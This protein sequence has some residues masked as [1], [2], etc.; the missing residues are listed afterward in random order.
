MLRTA[1]V[2]D[3]NRIAC[4]QA[5]DRHAADPARAREALD[6]LRFLDLSELEHYRR[7]GWLDREEI[8]LIERFAGFARERLHPVPA[9]VDPVAANRGVEELFCAPVFI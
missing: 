1:L 3:L 5:Q 9:G 8:D 2:E 4:P 7:Q 6:R